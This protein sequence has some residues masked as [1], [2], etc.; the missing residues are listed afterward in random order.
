VPLPRLLLLTTAATGVLSVGAALL[1]AWPPSMQYGLATLVLLTVYIALV[2]RTAAPRA[3]WAAVA[4]LAVLAVVTA[5]RLMWLPGPEGDQWEQTIDRQ[6]LAAAGVL[7]GVLCFAV[8]VLALPARYRPRRAVLT[9]TLALLVTAVIGFYVGRGVGGAPVLGL[10]RSAWPALTVILVAVG[11]V[12]LAGWRGDR[13]WL[14]LSGGALV[15]A[16]AA[17][18]FHELMGADAA[19]RAAPTPDAVPTP[20]ADAVLQARITVRFESAYPHELRHTSPADRLTDQL[21]RMSPAL[22]AALALAGPV[23]LAVGLLPATRGTGEA[24]ASAE[25]S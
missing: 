17:I 24:H 18:A 5:V 20:D 10:L 19:F 2:G 6:R 11:L 12:A 21:A 23:L 15:A 14:L 25:S 9:T 16:A 7:L 8:G 13:T 4:G 22:E 3:R 1:S